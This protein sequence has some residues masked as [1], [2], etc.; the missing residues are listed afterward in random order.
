VEV[1]ALEEA[2]AAGAVGFARLPWAAIGPEGELQL[3]AE[4]LSVRCLQRPDGGLAE[5]GDDD[6]SLVAVVG[7]AY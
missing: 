1:T 2:S 5:E 6:S 4:A 7:R 3:A